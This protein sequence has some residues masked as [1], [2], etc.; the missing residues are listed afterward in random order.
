VSVAR[1]GWTERDNYFRPGEN[2]NKSLTLRQRN[3]ASNGMPCFSIAQM[4][5][6]GERCCN[7]LRKP[8]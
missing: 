1:E 3:R 4:S 6:Y 5:N 7:I 8:L 2:V